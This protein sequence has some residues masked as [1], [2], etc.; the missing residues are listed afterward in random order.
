MPSSTELRTS[1]TSFTVDMLTEQELNRYWQRSLSM[2][3]IIGLASTAATCFVVMSCDTIQFRASSRIFARACTPVFRSAATVPSEWSC[4]EINWSSTAFFW[5]F[6]SSCGS[7]DG[8]SPCS[9]ARA[10][11]KSDSE[12]S[13]KKSTISG[14]TYRPSESSA[15]RCA[16]KSRRYPI[17][18]PSTPRRNS[19]PASDA[20]SGSFS[21]T[22]DHTVT[23]SCGLNI[24]A[25]S[26]FPRASPNS[27]ASTC[28]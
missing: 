22:K 12:K 8:C 10:E 20:S 19:K 4:L 15:S 21:S 13:R 14:H 7:D 6:R 11:L 25:E 5:K 3:A 17:M 27:G 28:L 9:K 2:P 1:S 23:S 16:T 18:L 26:F 24:R